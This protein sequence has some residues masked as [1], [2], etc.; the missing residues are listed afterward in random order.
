M[1]SLLNLLKVEKQYMK[2]VICWEPDRSVY[3]HTLAN[4]NLNCP[5]S[6]K[7]LFIVDFVDLKTRYDIFMTGRFYSIVIL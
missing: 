7:V 3:E 1:F 6:G 4:L 5:Q 2:D